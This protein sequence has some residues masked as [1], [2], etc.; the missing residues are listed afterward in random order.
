MF[1]QFSLLSRCN[2]IYSTV[3]D[4]GIATLF[5]YSGGLVSHR[6]VKV[7]YVDL[8]SFILIFHVWSQLW[9]TLGTLGG[10][11]RFERHHYG[12][13]G[14]PYHKQMCLSCRLVPVLQI[15]EPQ[16]IEAASCS[17]HVAYLAT[18]KYL[19]EICWYMKPS[20]TEL[21]SVRLSSCKMWRRVVWWKFTVFSKKPVL[22]L[23]S[24][25][26]KQKVFPSCLSVFTRLQRITYRKVATLM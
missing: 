18:C 17:C 23:L 21:R 2:P 11:R 12:K 19:W 7:K 26:C 3:V 14:W 5:K 15:N 9:N 8:D 24:W 4:G 6:N 10:R 1:L 25:R 13:S 22:I 20:A 16:C